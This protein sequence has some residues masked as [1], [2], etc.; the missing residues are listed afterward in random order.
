MQPSEPEFPQLRRS[1]AI[2]L[3]CLFLVLWFGTLEYRELFHPDEGRYAEI[4]REMLASGDWTTPRLN[5]FK[6][7]EKPVLQ[8]W[9][10]AAAYG[11]LGE[12]E[13]TARLW[14]A[15]SGL[16]TLLLV[17]F[18]GKRLA[19]ARAGMA[20]ALSLA[21]TFQFFLFSQ[22]L[23][24]DMGLTFFLTLALGSFLASQDVRQTPVQRRNWAVL[25]WVAMALAVLS[26]GLIGVVL[27][28]LVLAVYI[29]VE[30]D[31]KLLGRLCWGPGL[32]AFLVIALPWFTVVQLRNPEFWQFFFVQEH[33]SRYVLNEHNRDGAWY[34]FVGV[35]LVGSLPMSFAYLKAAA[36]SWRKPSPGNIEIRAARLLVLWVVVIVVF[37]S[38][39]A[40]KLP[41]YILP[42]YPALA[43]LLGYRMQQ[44][45]L[46]LLPQHLIV[47]GA[48]GLAIAG[49]APLI[50]HVPYF[51][52]DADLI[53]PYVAWLVGGGCTLAVA[54]LVAWLAMRGGRR[55]ALPV[56]VFG[57][58]LA[59]QVLVA[60]TQ[61][62][63]NEFSSEHLVERAQ[64]KMGEFDSDVPFYTVG[65]YDQ[66]L[67]LH[68]GRTLTVVGYRGELAMGI[69]REPERAISS[70]EEFRKLW[71]AHPQAYAIVTPA[72]FA[73]EQ[74]A[75][76][77]MVVLA[78]NRKAVIVAREPPSEST[79]RPPRATL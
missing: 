39:S 3:V 28:A 7:F 72:R 1:T 24:L 52:G 25:A 15:V 6:Y 11:V 27:P 47:M 17:Y 50:A 8:Y 70:I 55:F 60:G 49:A 32:L 29:V 26:K 14:P 79:R 42:V 33:V 75:G 57:T 2:S 69:S 18:M 63:A 54:A 40:S 37:F 36:G 31:W 44:E 68:I 9:I 16:L 65:M 30:R 78:S 76:V 22:V 61:S 43:V 53:S 10:T 59:F 41:G 23:T 48:T 64:D 20:A 66:T 21:C 67:P 74:A 45:E 5:E 73:E 38:V 34:Y 62:I 58:L 19:G 71:Q 51:A 13:W 12:D 35:L 4:P 56:V 77:P 46:R